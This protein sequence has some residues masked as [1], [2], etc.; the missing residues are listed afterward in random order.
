MTEKV[1]LNDIVLDFSIYPRSEVSAANVK[2][3]REAVETGATI[4]PI[5]LWRERMCPTDGFH[6]VRAAREL[7][8]ETIDAEL[9]DY[10]DETEA[11]LDAIQRNRSHGL[12]L[13]R[14]DLQR[15]IARL[16]SAGY[17]R[18]RIAEIVRIPVGS[19][20]K[21]V[22]NFGETPSGGVVPIKRGLE[23]LRG[24]TLS[25]KAEAIN[26]SYA[27]FPAS[28][29]AKQV[30]MFLES[31]PPISAELEAEMSL[32]IDVWLKAEK[33]SA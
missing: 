17:E 25:K 13:Q 16:Q 29:Y 33:K 27:G 28:F 4:P 8:W 20:E 9:V 30:R 5:V 11:F 32:L 2:L 24:T 7:E 10:A 15:A 23:H 21:I 18:D 6:R 19:I 12:P 1:K 22:T 3:I 14:Y 31:S 26:D